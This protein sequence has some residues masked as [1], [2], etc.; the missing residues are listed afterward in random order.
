[1]TEG[2]AGRNAR[3]L[4]A[5]VLGL[6]SAAGQTLAVA[7]SLTGGLVAA[8]LT[9][10][11]GSSVAFRGGIVAYATELK[12]EL[13][14]VDAAM[15]AAHGPVYPAVAAAMAAGVRDRLGATVGAATTGVAGPG[16]Q[17]GQPAG[18][19]H[20]AVSMPGSVAHHGVAHH[21]A[22]HHAVAHH[23]VAHHNDETI[24]RSVAL[25]G[26]RDEVRRLTVER[27]LG[28]L[29]GRLREECP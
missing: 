6:L 25:N 2:V 19:V 21:G 27:V 29:L 20:I 7:E 12:A 18:T 9:D 24:V 14:G 15:L 17:D 3:E 26:D 1:M 22:A 11:P 23:A 5:E 8:A 4:A 28:L 13:L 16:P 10:V